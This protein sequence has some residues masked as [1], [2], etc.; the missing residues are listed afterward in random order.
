MAEELGVVELRGDRVSEDA[1]LPRR[2][3][4]TLNSGKL[5]AFTRLECV[6]V[7][8]RSTHALSYGAGE[9]LRGTHCSVALTEARLS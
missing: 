2:R 1:A 4:R 6:L 3:H 7:D 8:L 9:R 5:S